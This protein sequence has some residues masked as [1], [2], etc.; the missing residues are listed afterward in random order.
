M[1]I[2]PETIKEIADMLAMGMLCFY[3][4]TTGE[5]EYYPDELKNPGYDEELWV[6]AIDRVAENYGDYLRLEGMS[7][8]ESFKVMENFIDGINHI[9]THNRFIAAISKKKPFSHFNDLIGYYPQLRQEWF[10]FKDACYIDF[11]KRQIEDLT[12]PPSI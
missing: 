3:H 7:S 9:P 11:V 5:L 12:M 8:R 4:K 10:L 6:E 1:E 2:K